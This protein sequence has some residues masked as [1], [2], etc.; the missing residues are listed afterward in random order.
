[1]LTSSTAHPP[2]AP[3]DK[4]LQPPTSAVAATQ[5]CWQQIGVWGD[6]SCETLAQVPHC[7]DCSTYR[8]AGEEL[9]SRPLP[10]KYL[11]EQTAQT[12]AP[13]P[14]VQSGNAQA[15]LIFRLGREWLALEAR[16]C[17]QILSPIAA[18]RLPHRSN[19]TLLGLVNVR[20]QLLLKVSLFDILGLS[21]TASGDRSSGP[22]HSDPDPV[23][24][25]H[26]GSALIQCVSGSHRG[27][28]IKTYARMVVI[29]HGSEIW[30]FEAQELDGIH[31]IRRDQLEITA[32]GGRAAC[33]SAVF[34]WRGQR[35]SFLDQQQLF[36]ALKQQ[37]L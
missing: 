30:V 36:E 25:H 13:P 29:G 3:S 10:E 2:S 34:P 15:A 16:F 7:Y 17:Q 23:G 37:A 32:P 4:P 26:P 21:A 28:D 8:A 9:L 27:G 31:S 6:R 12:A 24:H 20:G 18:H 22:P 14:S 35:V 11:Q 33:T 19:R 1:M 5:P